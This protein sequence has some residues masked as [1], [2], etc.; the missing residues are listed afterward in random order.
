MHAYLAHGYLFNCLKYSHWLRPGVCKQ[1]I[2]KTIQVF[3]METHTHSESLFI[4]YFYCLEEKRNRFS[5]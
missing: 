5:T 2:L 1:I 4:Y 3:N